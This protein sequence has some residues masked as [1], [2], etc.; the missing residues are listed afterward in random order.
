MNLNGKGE[1]LKKIHFFPLTDVVYRTVLGKIK[2]CCKSVLVESKLHPW[3]TQS[4]R[5][6]RR[7]DTKVVS[8]LETY[9]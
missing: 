1:T 5:E 3:S 4:F 2:L 9:D 6:P 8:L 7:R